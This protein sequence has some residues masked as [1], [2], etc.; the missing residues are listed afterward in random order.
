MTTIIITITIMFIGHM[1]VLSKIIKAVG[2]TESVRN[3][4]IHVSQKAVAAEAAVHGKPIDCRW[5]SFHERLGLL[6]GIVDIVSVA[7]LMITTNPDRVIS[8]VVSDRYGTIIKVQKAAKFQCQRLIFKNERLDLSKSKFQ[9]TQ[10]TYW[11]AI[12]SYAESRR[13]DAGDESK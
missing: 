1:L 2:I 3:F 6:I 4:C 11:A 12:I 7:I 9:R 8:S 13:S 10:N 5:G